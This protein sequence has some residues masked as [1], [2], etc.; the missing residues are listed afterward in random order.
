MGRQS[1]SIRDDNR[2]ARIGSPGHV[3]LHDVNERKYVRIKFT[4][5]ARPDLIIV[6]TSP[7]LPG[8]PELAGMRRTLATDY[9]L[10]FARTVAGDDP[11]NIY[12]RQDDFYLPLA[13]F[14]GIERPGPNLHIYIRRGAFPNVPR[15]V[16]PD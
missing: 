10:G 13:G 1:I 2:T 3:F 4:R 15:I 11:D 6:P 7:L 16:R 14:K 9:E 12:D 8:P 5:R